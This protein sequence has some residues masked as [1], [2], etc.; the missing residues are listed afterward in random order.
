LFKKHNIASRTLEEANSLK[1]TTERKEKHS[2]YM[3]G[4][5]MCLGKRWKMSYKVNKNNSGSNNPAWKGGV[6]SFVLK[7]R[8]S[9]EYKAWR[10]LVYKRDDYTCQSCG[11]KS[12]GNLNAHHIVSFS[13]LISK[14]EIDS[15]E[16]GVNCKNLWSVDNG[17][18]LCLECHKT[19]ESYLHSKYDPSRKRNEKG[20]FTRD[21]YGVLV[22]HKDNIEQD[23]AK[24]QWYLNKAKELRNNL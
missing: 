12:G 2:N 1:W 6:T 10:Q 17:I 3:N 19:T 23:L 7:L 20:Q 9:D 14:N 18:T 4:K 13:E 8:N 24:E 11:D 16:K 5:K 15:F 21:K 22:G